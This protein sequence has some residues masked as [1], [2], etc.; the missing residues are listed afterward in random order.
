MHG[1]RKKKT[2]G[3]VYEVSK[4]ARNSKSIIK[5]ILTIDQRKQR[6]QVQQ[7]KKTTNQGGHKRDTPEGHDTRVSCGFNCFGNVDNVR[8]ETVMQ[9]NDAVLTIFLPCYRIRKVW[10]W[11]RRARLE[12]IGIYWCMPCCLSR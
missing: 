1:L 10:H 6:Q 11:I 4:F 9:S 2:G 3:V 5:H 12:I 7:N 8:N